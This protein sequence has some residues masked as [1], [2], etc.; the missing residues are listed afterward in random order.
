VRD[1][2]NLELILHSRPCPDLLKRLAKIY[3]VANLRYHEYKSEEKAND[4]GVS[5][6]SAAL[7]RN[8][9]KSSARADT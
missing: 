3:Q 1:N 6:T 9:D 4:E 8:A 5:T 7:T 2:H